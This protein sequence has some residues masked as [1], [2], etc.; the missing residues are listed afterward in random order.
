MSVEATEKGLLPAGPAADAPAGAALAS[1]FRA[2]MVSIAGT[3]FLTG[4]AMNGMG[5][6]LPLYVTA[7]LHMSNAA[8]G[9]VLSLRG[10][11]IAVGVTVLGAL[12]DRFG[13]RRSAIGCLLLGGVLYALLGAVPLWAFL[14][15]VATVSGLL[16]T[17]LINTNTLTQLVEQRRQGLANSVY[18]ASTI[19]A[20][21]LA[22]VL[23]TT[24]L[25]RT[26]SFALVFAVLG[27]LWLLG[28][29]SLW[30]YP[31]HEPW[32]PPGAW[33]QEV[34]ALKEIYLR[35]LRQKHL[36]R[37][38]HLSLV[39]LTIGGSAAAFAAIRLTRELGTSDQ[40]YGSACSLAAVLSLAGVAV[41]G[42]LLDRVPIKAC[43]SV[44]GAISGLALVVM[45][46]ADTPVSTAA[47][48][49]VFS[50]ALTL[51]VAPLSV[52]ISRESLNAGLTAAF[53]VHK[54]AAA[55][56]MAVIT[57]LI[58]LLEPLLGIRGIFLVCGAL[59]AVLS[60]VMYVG[61]R[62]PAATDQAPRA[63]TFEGGPQTR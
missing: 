32:R 13:A 1:T 57:F 10:I 16:S 59:T 51:L 35:A 21:I 42:L 48:F 44:L 20:A 36:M 58:S 40:Y 43:A 19:A 26:G 38:V 9:R 49:V 47:G 4:F 34:G 23:A 7:G 22:P 5:V 6:V 41:M 12:S 17:V 63:T 37:F 29:G 8:Y 11:G 39:T 15:L 53:A 2:R 31:I 25:A 45:A 50:L 18:R 54:V 14:V 33:R 55:V 24:L 56:Y 61:L 28:A 62:S 60:L 52:W 30:R 46:W 27:V 3:G